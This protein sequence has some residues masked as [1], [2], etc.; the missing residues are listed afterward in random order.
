V[1]PSFTN[2]LSQ[3]IFDPPS[4]I[5]IDSFSSYYLPPGSTTTPSFG[6]K[7]PIFGFPKGLGNSFFSSTPVVHIVGVYSLPETLVTLTQPLTHSSPLAHESSNILSSFFPHMHTPSNLLGPPIG[8]MTSI[9]VFHTTTTRQS[10]QPPYHTSQ[11]SNPYIGGKSSM[12]GQPST[13]G[14]PSVARKLFTRGKP[15]VARKLFTRG[16]PLVAGNFFT[17]ENLHSCNINKHG[18]KTL[19]KVLLSLLPLVCVLDIHIQNL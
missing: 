14:Q 11:I 9:Q 5:Y 16:Q 12:G 7:P 3:P 19:L 15:S 2:P 6:M 4:T 10:K 8:R 1:N 17:R 18:G 13:G